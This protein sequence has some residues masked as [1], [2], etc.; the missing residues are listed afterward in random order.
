MPGRLPVTRKGV[1]VQK[2]EVVL[3]V[4][5]DRWVRDL[6]RDILELFGHTVLAS[7]TREHAVDLCHNRAGEITLLILDSSSPAA[8]Y[9]YEKVL[10]LNPGVRVIVTTQDEDDLSLQTTFS[11][12]KAFLQKPYRMS[13]L[14]FTL[15]HVQE[16]S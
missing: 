11:R 7:E 9:I 13:E 10:L 1:A 16:M 14:M 2:G 4:D 6:T 3:V 8:G 5:D 12:A 15:E